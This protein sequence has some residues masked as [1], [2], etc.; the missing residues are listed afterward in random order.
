MSFPRPPI[1]TRSR[2]PVLPSLA[3]LGLAV[4]VV[5]LLSACGG[6][7]GGESVTPPPTQNQATISTARSGELLGYVRQRLQSRGPK[8]A[9]AAEANAPAWFMTSVSTSGLVSRGWTSTP[10]TPPG[11]R[12]RWARP[13]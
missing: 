6:G 1:P 7:G 8:G 12:S 5:A 13:R 9:A 10:A 3:V 2:R 4:A 11:G